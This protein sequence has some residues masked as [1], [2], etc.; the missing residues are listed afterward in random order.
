MTETYFVFS[1]RDKGGCHTDPMDK[2]KLQRELGPGGEYHGR[3][4]LSEMPDWD[5]VDD[6]IVIIK[7]EIIVPTAVQTVTEYQIP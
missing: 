1:Q 3:P 4:I 2:D 6:G 7:G 5:Y